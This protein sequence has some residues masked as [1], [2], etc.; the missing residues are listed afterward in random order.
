VRELEIERVSRV[1]NEEVPFFR[2]RLLQGN[3]FDILNRRLRIARH[4]SNARRFICAL[5]ENGTRT[6]RANT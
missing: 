5:D 1:I 4:P 6:S 3:G 2:E